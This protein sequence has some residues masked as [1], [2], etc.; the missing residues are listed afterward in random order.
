LLGADP[1]A[2]SLPPVTDV[3]WPPAADVT[4]SARAEPYPEHRQHAAPRGS[5]WAVAAALAV[6]ATWGTVRAIHGY[7]SPAAAV[8]NAALPV[9]APLA[10]AA[11]TAEVKGGIE[12]G[13]GEAGRSERDFGGEKIQEKTKSSP[14]PR[15]PVPS[16][17][18]ATKRTQAKT[19]GSTVARKAPSAQVAPPKTVAPPAFP[20]LDLAGE[21]DRNA[22]MQALCDAGDRARSCVARAGGG[23]LRVAVTFARTGIVSGAVVEGPL[24]GTSAATCVE[25]KFRTVR[26]PPFRGSSLTV[27]KTIAF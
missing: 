15:L 3:T 25:G 22:A 21:F 18:A 19:E 9:T 7:A 14:P 16:P 5:I 8:Q 23:S 10:S 27:R 6:T 24:A 17:V 4:P 13:G 2:F 20:G 26:V 11:A 12:Q 1:T